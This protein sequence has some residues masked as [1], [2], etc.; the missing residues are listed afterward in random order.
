MPLA[1]Q[2]VCNA[3]LLEDS[4]VQCEMVQTSVECALKLARGEA[5]LGAFAEEEMVLL[6]QQQPEAHRVIANIRHQDR[7]HDFAF[8]AVTVVSS[9]HSGGVDG[10]RGA[11][12]CHPGFDNQDLRWSPRVLRH[13]E[14]RAARTDRCAEEDLPHRTFEELEV[15]TLARFFGPSCRPGPWSNNATIDAQLKRDHPSLCRLCNQA[16]DASSCDGYDYEMGVQNSDMDSS[17]RHIQALQCL[18]Q[19]NNTVAYVAWTHVQQYFQ[20]APHLTPSYSLLC[21]NGVLHQLTEEALFQPISPC[22]WIRQPWGALVASTNRHQVLQSDLRAWWPDG[23]MP[24]TDGWQPLLFDSVV[25]GQEFVVNF[26]DIVPNAFE[27]VSGARTLH[28][29]SSTPQCQPSPRWCTT[30]AAEFSKCVWTSAALYTIGVQ[31]VL[32][33]TQR[34]DVFSCMQDIGDGR[35][36]FISVDS[37]YGYIARVHYNLA[38]IKLLQNSNADSSRVAA[39]VK[40]SAAESGEIN[41][42]ENLRGAR[43]CFP[44]YGGIA[45]MSF[46]RVAHERGIVSVSECD[47]G[48]A[49]GEFY[50]GA[51]APGAL[52]RDHSLVTTGFNSTVLCTVCRSAFPIQGPWPDFTCAADASNLYYGTNGTIACLNDADNNVAFIETQRLEDIIASQQLNTS[53]FR[54]LCRNNSLALSPGV[55][56]DDDCLLALVVNEEVLGRRNDNQLNSLRSLLSQMEDHFGYNVALPG[57]MINLQIFSEFDGVRD[58]LFMDSALGFTEPTLQT[59]HVPARNY[60]ELFSHLEQCNG[61]EG[62]A[63]KALVSFVTMF[64]MNIMIRWIL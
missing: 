46:V 25:G 47:Y 55:L 34:D 7:Q 56:L 1:R 30:N 58:L 63:N 19:H 45:F 12:L 32:T 29:I 53:G 36:D 24:S 52:D 11:G 39:L 59:N 22:A 2:V 54:A 4:R 15:P 31:P 41:R 64:L 40:Q 10:L 8:E 21:E 50:S 17:N 14:Q 13:L 27:Y 9:M 6:S 51:C 43:A 37:N 35:A 48:R 44:E 18:V 20:N 16:G 57:Q 49:V 38:S 28:S 5:D 26:F 61:A 3:L 60:I 42:F 23:R 62:I 33:C